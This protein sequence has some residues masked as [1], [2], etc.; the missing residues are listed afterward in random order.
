MVPG[1]S[2]DVVSNVWA[3]KSK[4]RLAQPALADE[5]RGTSM[6]RN[7]VAGYDTFLSFAHARI[8]HFKSLR[9]KADV[10]SLC[11][12]LDALFHSLGVERAKEELAAEF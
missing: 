7:A 2:N 8:P 6:M 4:S 9:N 10:L 5:G 1:V 12:A 3:G 11:R